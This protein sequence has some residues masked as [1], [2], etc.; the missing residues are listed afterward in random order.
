MAHSAGLDAG[1]GMDDRRTRVVA[2]AKQVRRDNAKTEQDAARALASSTSS[3]TGA[4]DEDLVTLDLS[5]RA[6]GAPQKNFMQLQLEQQRANHEA[7]LAR[8]GQPSRSFDERWC[9]GDLEANVGVEELK[10]KP[11]LP[12]PDPTCW[13]CGCGGI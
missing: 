7:H 2:W 13:D 12:P 10:P 4:R 9:G 8:Q 3:S 11:P 1:L 5:S 6:S